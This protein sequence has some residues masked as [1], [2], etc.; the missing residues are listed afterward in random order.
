MEIQKLRLQIMSYNE[1]FDIVLELCKLGF[2]VLPSGGGKSG[3]APLVK[4]KAWQDKVPDEQQLRRWQHIRRPT[5]WGI[6]TNSGVAVIDAD[7]SEAQ[8]QLQTELGAP[9]VCTPKGSHWYI[10]TTRH[11]LKTV[12]GILPGI[13]V[14]GVGGFVNIIG[15][16]PKTGGE[17]KISQLPAPENLIPYDELPGSILNA[18]DG[19]GSVE[20]S[21]PEAELKALIPEGQRNGHLTSMAGSMR[22]SGFGQSAIEAALLKENADKCQPPLEVKEV[23]SIAR[24][25]AQYEPAQAGDKKRLT[26][27]TQLLELA[28]D[29]EL[30]HTP[31]RMPYAVIKQGGHVEVWPLESRTVKDYLSR[32]YYKKTGS[33]P[34]LQAIQNAFNVFRGHALFD[35]LEKSVYTRIAENDGKIYL[36]LCNSV[37]SVVEIT[38]KTWQVIPFPPVHFVRSRGMVALP[39]PQ[40]G[41]DINE[42]R[43]FLNTTNDDWPLLLAWLIGSFMPKGPFPVLVLTGEQGSAKSTVARIIRSLVDPS[44]ILLRSLPRDERDLAI[45]AGNSWIMAFDNVSYLAPWQSDAICRLATG[46]GFTTRELY[47]NTEEVLF[48]TTRPVM[49]NGIGDIATRS[50]LL[51]RAI[52][53]VL[54]TIPNHKRRTEVDLQKEFKRM[55]PMFLALLLDAVSLALRDMGTVR[56]DD[57]PRMADFAKWVVAA[58]PAL[59]VAPN[60][61]LDAYRGNIQDINHLALESAP[62]AREIMILASELPESGEWVGTATELLDKLSFEAGDI[63]ERRKDW[64]KNPR[65]LGSIIS[66]LAP[67]FRAIGVD[68]ARDRGSERLIYI[69][70]GKQNY[71]TPAKHKKVKIVTKTGKKLHINMTR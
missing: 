23:R 8:E 45:A 20:K 48:A 11:P 42:L 63:A 39:A 70:K 54:P 14:R 10:D 3:K 60:D 64:P 2:T 32:R 58:I 41:G 30:F 49:L 50:D 61:F 29:I 34:S 9:H 24:S 22:R 66:R 35:G 17:Y 25:V 53:I 43:D 31:D 18:L 26:V 28:K 4:W 21:S 12:A 55:C 65:A 52:I 47:A 19:N 51:D 6:V 7:T 40:A 67:N 15:K 37:W 36:D 5:L 44:T 69:R 62:A 16:N 46:G 1:M 59:N 57:M 38:A 27:A 56:L 13:D 68:I 71:N 33:A